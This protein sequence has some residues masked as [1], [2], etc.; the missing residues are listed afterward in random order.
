[1]TESS[2]KLIIY[3][4]SK[5]MNDP[6]Y[7]YSLAIIFISLGISLLGGLIGS[8]IRKRNQSAK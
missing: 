6:S 3:E 7:L 1:M 4:R 5:N 8:K 2:F